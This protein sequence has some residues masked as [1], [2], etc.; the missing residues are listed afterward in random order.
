MQ[1]MPDEA[2]KS[3]WAILEAGRGAGSVVAQVVVREACQ[4]AVLGAGREACQVAVLGA[5]RGVCTVAGLGATWEIGM[6]PP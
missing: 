4:V 1:Q 5:G 3:K 6:W 2:Y